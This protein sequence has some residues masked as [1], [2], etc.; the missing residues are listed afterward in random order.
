MSPPTTTTT[1]SSF[2]LF[3][4]LLCLPSLSQATPP[5]SIA[6]AKRAPS[7]YRPWRPTRPSP[8]SEPSLGYFAPAA[9]GGSMLTEAPN[10]GDPPLGEPL[11][12]IVAGTSDSAVLVDSQQNGGFRNYMLSIGFSAECL[13]Q[14]EGAPQTANLGDGNGYQNETN[15]LRWDY[16]DPQIGTC[17]ETIQGGNHFRY[18]VQNGASGNSSAIFMATSYELPIAQAHNIIS[19]GYNLGRDWLVG[20]ITGNFVNTS[21]VTNQTTFSGTTSFGN[22][23]YQTAIAYVGGLLQDNGNGVNHASD[24]GVNGGSPLDGLVAVLEVKITSRPPSSPS[25]AGSRF[26]SLMPVPTALLLVL[27]ALCAL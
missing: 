16:G 1:S 2:A 13:G 14:H 15:E 6:N 10:T 26:S 19:N 4:L 8:R 3:F 21:A 5:P 20:N 7:P 17:K 11:N 22:Y 27:G 12:I 25:R 18:W 24:V 23:T 9:A